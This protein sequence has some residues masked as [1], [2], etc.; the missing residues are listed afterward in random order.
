MDLSDH[1]QHQDTSITRI[2]FLRYGEAEWQ[3]IAGNEFAYCNRLRAS[4][5]LA[6]FQQL[7]FTID[8]H[9]ID[10]DQEAMS[11]IKKKEFPLNQSF[12]SYTPEDICSTSL[13][14]LLRIHET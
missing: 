4:D 8:R 3:C 11:D 10:V 5:Y 13:R 14:L 2:N 6:L 9:E 12:S 7:G 1:F